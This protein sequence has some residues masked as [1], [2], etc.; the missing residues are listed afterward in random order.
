MKVVH[1]QH[2]REHQ[3]YVLEGKGKF[4]DNNREK[5]PLSEGMV[6]YVPPM[7]KHQFQNRGEGKF[8]FLCTIPKNKE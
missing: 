8:K 6:V 3:V 7:E 5:H 2:K 4:V 1:Y